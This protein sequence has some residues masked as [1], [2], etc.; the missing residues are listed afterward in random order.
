MNEDA[1]AK[2]I[3]KTLKRSPNKLTSETEKN[4]RL[5]SLHIALLRIPKGIVKRILD[6]NHIRIVQYAKFHMENVHS[7][8]VIT[9][10]A[11]S[12]P[13]SSLWQSPTVYLTSFSPVNLRS[14]IIHKHF[15]NPHDL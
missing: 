4:N 5:V 9:L 10:A 12:G 8:S 11:A 3:I 1:D 2:M 14:R 15:P 6:K 7:E 13:L